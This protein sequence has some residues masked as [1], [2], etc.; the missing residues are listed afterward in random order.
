M[1]FEKISGSSRGSGQPKISLRKSNSIG[2]NNAA[3]DE[4][5]DDDVEYVEFYYDRDAD[6]LG[7]RPLEEESD[8]SYSL[9]RTDSGGTAA[10]TS[11]L[12]AESLVP[13]VTTQ[14]E[15]R[16]QKLNNDVEL[17]VIDLDDEIGTYGHPDS[18]D[19]EEESDDIDEEAAEEDE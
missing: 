19:S 12:K 5:F 7:I 4:Y 14:Y 8:D 9:S 3:L 17:V 11:F 2:I 15:P 18:E 10:P 13:D 6:T 1:G 16:T